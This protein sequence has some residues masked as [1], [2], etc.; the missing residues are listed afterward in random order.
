MLL[1][2]RTLARLK[3][4]L[5][6]KLG[7]GYADPQNAQYGCLLTMIGIATLGQD[8]WKDIADRRWYNSEN[9][10]QMLAEKTGIDKDKL[11]H[12]EAGFEG[13]ECDQNFESVN[14][15]HPQYKVGQRVDKAFRR[16][17]S[18]Y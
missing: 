15:N 6:F 1:Q 13:W 5:G 11:R 9:V 4:K 10:Y 18:Y 7:W 3:N 14:K 12:L 2:F 8:G 16:T 17:P